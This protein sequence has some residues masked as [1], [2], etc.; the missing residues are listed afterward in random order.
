MGKPTVFGIAYRPG[1]RFEYT[2]FQASPNAAVFAVSPDPSSPEDC[3]EARSTGLY[4]SLLV[5]GT[6]VAIETLWSV[7]E[8][9]KDRTG[10]QRRNA[11]SVDIWAKCKHPNVVQLLGKATVLPE[12]NIAAVYGWEDYRLHRYLTVSLYLKKYPTTLADRFQ[13]SVS[14]SAGVAYL[15]TLKIVSML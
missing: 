7:E 6:Q 11:Q 9:G 2:S 13:L 8:N 12:G 15:H 4:I 5:N 3:I 14:I 1:S 10:R